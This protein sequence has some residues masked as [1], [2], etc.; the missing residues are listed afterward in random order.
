MPKQTFYPSNKKQVTIGRQK[1]CDFSFPKDK[2]FSRIQT[3]FEYY[4]YNKVWK[5]IDGTKEKS[6]TN[7]TWVF[8]IHS[9][10]IEN[11]MTIEILNSKINISLVNQ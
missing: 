10:P 4:E 5:I 6:S 2:S 3:T 9:F 8:G 1:D 11:G 7:G